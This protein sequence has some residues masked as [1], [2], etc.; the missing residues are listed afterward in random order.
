MNQT[1]QIIIALI[2]VHIMT[3]IGLFISKRI[4][5]LENF[6]SSQNHPASKGN[7]A[8]QA[9]GGIIVPV[10]LLAA[11][12]L[13]NTLTA[14]PIKIQFIFIS[15]VIVLF[16]TGLIDDYKPISAFIR[17]LIHFLS[18]VTITIMIFHLT[19]FSGINGV[20]NSFG[21]IAPAIFMVLAISWM[22]N[23]TNFIDGMDLFLAI[24]IIPGIIFF[25]F[26]DFFTND[27]FF[28]SAIFSILLSSLI[29]FIWFN[30]PKASIYMGDAGTLSLGFI[31]GSC[32]V[33]LLA[34]YGSIFGFIPFAYMLV[35]TTFTLIN[36][37]SKGINPFKSHN[38]HAYQIASRQ[39]KTE[40]HIRSYC[41]VV[42]ILNSA[43]AYICL[44]LGNALIWQIILGI[45]AFIISSCLF[46]F[47]RN[48]RGLGQ[49][50]T[51]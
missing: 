30:K 14:L 4:K 1:E 34:K 7:T 46:F 24:S 35:D 41:L 15:P 13:L 9:G 22:I 31:I 16:A 45:I 29:G 50:K 44:Q 20:V 47:L 26:L 37:I 19:Q 21:Y 36:R 12:I 51:I 40:N 39:A 32:G 38:Q 17:L 8:F 23:T 10:V 11:I 43:L 48:D 42:T 28:I 5:F 49:S 2:L 25:C 18:A 33:Y 6:R 3:V 27:E